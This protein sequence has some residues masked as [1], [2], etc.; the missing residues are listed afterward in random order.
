MFSRKE[1]RFLSLSVH[2]EHD[3]LESVTGRRRT[4]HYFNIIL[5][6][7]FLCRV[8][9]KTQLLVRYELC[10]EVDFNLLHEK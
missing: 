3:S 4:L 2:D 7:T 5:W 9:V 8:F 1:S 6:F 10:V